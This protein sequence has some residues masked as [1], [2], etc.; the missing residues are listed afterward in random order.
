MD[1]YRWR[2]TTYGMAQMIEIWTGV[3]PEIAEDP[4]QPFVFRV[5][6][7]PPPDGE[8]DRAMVEHLLNY[9]KPAASGYVLEIAS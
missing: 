5:R 1:L 3:T 2:G 8:I 6:V 9:H 4:D 7:K